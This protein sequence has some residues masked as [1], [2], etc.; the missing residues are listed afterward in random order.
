MD[1]RAKRLYRKLTRTG[2]SWPQTLDGTTR[3]KLIAAYTGSLLA[4]EYST[5][6]S[7]ELRLNEM[8]WQQKYWTA[9]QGGAV[10][11]DVSN[12]IVT[13]KVDETAL[14][15]VKVG[16]W[17]EYGSGVTIVRTSASST[18]ALGIVTAIASNTAS[19]MTSGYL[20]AASI[21]GY[22]A[23][24]ERT[25]YSYDPIN[26]VISDAALELGSASSRPGTTPY[27]GQSWITSEDG[28][29]VLFK[30]APSTR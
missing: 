2:S 4:S 23:A 30:V 8:Y 28:S 15:S 9:S 18:L 24:D 17:V 12:V 19:V 13:R 14:D 5:S 11:S 25:G 29:T 16:H 27:L 21:L 22:L 1:A 3:S 10:E 26:W 7:Q 6:S 20:T